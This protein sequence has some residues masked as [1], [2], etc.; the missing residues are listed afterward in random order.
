M[1]VGGGNN[2]WDTDNLGI[3]LSKKP[4]LDLRG[5]FSGVEARDGM[6]GG[7]DDELCGWSWDCL[8]GIGGGASALPWS[9]FS[10]REKHNLYILSFCY[11]YSLK[12]Y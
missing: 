11:N 12:W 9:P 6:G 4:T 1:P 2:E 7:S 3:H 8:S 10:V 5:V